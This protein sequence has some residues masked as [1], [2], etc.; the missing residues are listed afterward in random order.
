VKVS[1]SG[2]EHNFQ[3]ARDEGQHHFVTGGGGKY[4]DDRLSSSGMASEMVQAW[5]GKF[6]LLLPTISFS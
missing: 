2:H 5:G 6:A 1:F 4:R 3:Y